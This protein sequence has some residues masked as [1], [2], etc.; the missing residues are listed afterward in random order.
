MVA[1]VRQVKDILP[2]VSDL[3][4]SFDGFLQL[5]D[6][7]FEENLMIVKASLR[8]LFSCRSR[9]GPVAGANFVQVIATQSAQGAK[10]RAPIGGSRSRFVESIQYTI[11]YLCTFTLIASFDSLISA[12]ISLLFKINS[13]F[14]LGNFLE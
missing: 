4:D 12:K 3:L 11:V 13:L 8:E 10:G 2:R 9:D 6:K 5:F 14:R 1:P 7:V